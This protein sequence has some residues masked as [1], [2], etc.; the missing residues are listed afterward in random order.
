[1][2]FGMKKLFLIMYAFVVAAITVLFL[3]FGER[4][5]PRY[6]IIILILVIIGKVLAKIIDN[7]K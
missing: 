4:K 2:R 3:I 1:M 6:Y 5:D 7:R